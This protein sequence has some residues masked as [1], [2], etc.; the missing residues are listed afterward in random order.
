MS[1]ATFSEPQPESVGSTIAR[2][3]AEL[4]TKVRDAR[5]GR[6]WT[7]VELGRRAGVS[8]TT[9]YTIERGEQTSLEA[10]V[11]VGSALGLRFEANL[12]D[13]RTAND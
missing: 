7:T 6:N 5:L 1:P 10:V 12:V 13:P 9:V 2:I 4:G 8:R 11:R 3:W